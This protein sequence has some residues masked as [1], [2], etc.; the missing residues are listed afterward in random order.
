VLSGFRTRPDIGD[1]LDELTQVV[2]REKRGL[3]RLGF[4]EVALDN[5]VLQIELDEPRNVRIAVGRLDGRCLVGFKYTAQLFPMTL[6]RAPIRIIDGT[7]ASS[8]LVDFVL[9]KDVSFEMRSTDGSVL[10]F[11]KGRLK[12]GK[13]IAQNIEDHYAAA[14]FAKSIAE[15]FGISFTT[16]SSATRNAQ[17]TRSALTNK[18]SLAQ[19]QKQKKVSD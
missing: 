13:A 6:I 12:N 2:Q 11:T 10:P 9:Y 7:K 18:S 4:G 3:K 19:G 15:V 16:S 5:E 1:Y 17:N 14:K 8:H